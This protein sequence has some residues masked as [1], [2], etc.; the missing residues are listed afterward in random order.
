[1]QEGGFVGSG[2]RVTGVGHSAYAAG[3]LV[4]LGID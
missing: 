3:E 1:M 2:W 4:R